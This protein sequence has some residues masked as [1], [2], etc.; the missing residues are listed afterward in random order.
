MADIAR[1]VTDRLAD[2]Y[3]RYP[4]ATLATAQLGSRTQDV[5]NQF[6]ADAAQRYAQTPTPVAEAPVAEQP[7][8]QS[9]ET[10]SLP[11]GS[12]VVNVDGVDIA[13]PPGTTY[14]P[15]TREIV[16]PGGVRIP[17]SALAGG[18]Q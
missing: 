10:P 18:P 4:A 13:L 15:A 5:E 6:L 17:L 1:P 3:Q 16:G 8:W 11:E 2:L 9:P 12:S 14:D 7:V